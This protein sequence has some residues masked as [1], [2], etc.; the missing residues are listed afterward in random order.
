M[1][2]LGDLSQV[3]S[4]QVDESGLVTIRFSKKG[5]YFVH[6]YQINGQELELSVTNGPALIV[7]SQNACPNIQL[8]GLQS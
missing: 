1:S 6:S 7:V 2:D 5:Q 8:S 3:A 4:Y